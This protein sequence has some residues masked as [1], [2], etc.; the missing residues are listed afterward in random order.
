MSLLDKIDIRDRLNVDDLYNTF[1]GFDRRQQT[2]VSIG[3][4]FVVLLLLFLPLS[5]VNSAL[6]EQQQSYEEELQRASELYGLLNQYESVQSKIAKLKKDSSSLGS[7]PLKQ[8]IYE[9]ADQVGIERRAISPSTI[10]PKNGEF[11][12]ELTKEVKIKN[13][14]F[15]HLMNFLNGLVRFDKIPVSVRVLTM[16]ADPRRKGYMRSVSLTLVTVRPIS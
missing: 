6:N 5:C 4:V 9:I 11:F 13:I 10:P 14:R 2:L 8:V 15:D 16:E 12:S 1:L 7:D 3:V